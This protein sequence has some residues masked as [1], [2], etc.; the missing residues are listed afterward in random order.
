MNEYGGIFIVITPKIL[1]KALNLMRKRQEVFV[2]TGSFFSRFINGRGSKL[3]LEARKKRL[4]F[5]F[6]TQNQ[7]ACK[8]RI[9]AS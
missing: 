9:S 8:I 1:K 4:S 7:S 5:P 2:P 3:M 6:V